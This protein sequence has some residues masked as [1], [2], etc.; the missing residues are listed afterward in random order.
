LR[1]A[2]SP[3][4][5]VNRE[6][7]LGDVDEALARDEAD[8][9]GEPRVG[10]LVAVAATHA[11]ADRD[12]VPRQ[13]AV[14]HNGDQAEVV[15]EDVDVVHRRDRERRLELPRQVSLAVKRVHEALF[16]V[17]LQR[18]P[19]DPDRR[20]GPGRGPERVRDLHRVFENLRARRR[21]GRS[22]SRHHVAVHVAARR[23]GG[24]QGI[25]DPVHQLP[26]ARLQH[27]VELDALARGEPQRV[28]AVPRRQ[29]VEDDPLRRRHHPAR[30][31]APHHHH[32]LLARLAEIAVVLLVDP[33]ELQKLFVIRGKVILRGI[34]QGLRQRSPQG[35]I[36][37][38]ENLVLAYGR[39]GIFGHDTNKA[40][41]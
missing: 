37:L 34:G 24:E 41:T 30:N 40:C 2:R 21:V 27:A 35:G 10:G 7:G 15:R 18:L 23:Q 39:C 28:V 12:V 25:V 22:R 36:A 8:H 17:Q 4:I 31:P 3:K 33:V 6:D 11:A 1:F 26:H 38:L 29:I 20:V 19:L 16:D 13:P 32:V 9:V 5:A 14:L